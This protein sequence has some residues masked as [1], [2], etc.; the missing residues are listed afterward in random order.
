MSAD[1]KFDEVKE[2]VY[3]YLMIRKIGRASTDVQRRLICPKWKFS[4]R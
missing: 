4:K 3:Q 2:N 1:E